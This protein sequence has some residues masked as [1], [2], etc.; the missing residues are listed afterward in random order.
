[1]DESET[2]LGKIWY[3]Y[4][5]LGWNHKLSIH[6]KTIDNC[7]IK[8]YLIDEINGRK[9][10]KW[11]LSYV[12]RY[13]TNKTK[14]YKSVLT[15]SLKVSDKLS[16]K[17]IIEFILIKGDVESL[18]QLIFVKT[19]I[20]V[21]LEDKATIKREH[22]EFI[23]TIIPII[24]IKTFHYDLFNRKNIILLASICS[25]IAEALELQLLAKAKRYK[26]F[27]G[28][29]KYAE[30]FPGANHKRIFFEIFKNRENYK[31]KDALERLRELPQLQKYFLMN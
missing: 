1:M 22:I 11:L 20:V 5:S 3:A 21:N 28:L 14:V 26:D 23:K 24:G 2:L 6:L 10:L 7:L 15:T 27:Y 16:Q 18:N 8:L 19:N 13:E 9:A 25:S 31:A 30:I 4:K 29:V 17:D 12:T